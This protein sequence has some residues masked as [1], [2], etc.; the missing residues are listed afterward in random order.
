MRDQGSHHSC[1]RG[2]PGAIRQLC[3]AEPVRRV[4]EHGGQLAGHH[5]RHGCCQRAVR[6]EH[7][8]RHRRDEQRFHRYRG[9]GSGRAADAQQRRAAV[10]FGRG[11]WHGDARRA[12]RFRSRRRRQPGRGKP[13]CGRRRGNGCRRRQHGDGDR[14]G[15]A[16][17]RPFH[18]DRRQCRAAWH[19]DRQRYQHRLRDRSQYHSG[20]RHVLGGGRDDRERGVGRHHHRRRKIRRDQRDTRRQCRGQRDAGGS[21]RRHTQHRPRRSV[22]WRACDQRHRDA[23][24]EREQPADTRPG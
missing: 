24:A 11:A 13:E 2:R 7:G 15:D 4:L 16:G 14:H 23:A 5:D 17:G 10:R 12:G 22:R 20:R 6:L 1:R 19:I 9:H 3:L 21:G 18:L 8:Q